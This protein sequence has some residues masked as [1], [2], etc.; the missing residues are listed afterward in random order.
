MVEAEALLEEA[1]LLLGEAELLGAVGP[2]AAALLLLLLHAAHRE[3]LLA[4]ARRLVDVQ[5]P[6]VPVTAAAVV[7]SKP[8]YQTKHRTISSRKNCTPRTGTN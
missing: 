8:L 5:V 3:L 6:H 7:A 1:G 4:A 2:T